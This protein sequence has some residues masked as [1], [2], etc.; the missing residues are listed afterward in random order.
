MNDKALYFDI[1]SHDAELV[2]DMPSNEFFRLGQFA[3]GRNGKVE[4]TD[5]RK[6][7]VKQVRK[8]D[9]VIGHNIH[10]FD[11]TAIFGKDSSEPLE[12]AA[13]RKVFDTMVHA[14]LVNQAP[15]SY[16]NRK[17]HTFYTE[18]NVGNVQKWFGLDQQCFSLN[19]EGKIGDLK[20][21]AKKYGGYG[22]IPLDDPEFVQYAE[23]DVEAV[24]EYAA[25]LKLMGGPGF[26]WSYAWREQLLW[27]LDA[28]NTRNG[29][30]VDRERAQARYDELLRE[31]DIVMAMLVEAYDFPTEGKQPWKSK[32]GKEAIFN[33][34]AEVGI[35]PG[36]RP[37]WAKTATGNPSLGGEV[38]LAL[39]EGTPA[40][41]LGRGL[42]TLLGQRSL[43]ELALTSRRAD[44]KAHPGITRFQ[45][46]GR[47]SVTKPGLTVW[48]ARGEGA[49]EKAYFTASPGRKLVEL[50]YSN[51]DARIVAAL[52]G[53][54]EFA[55]RFAPGVDGHELTGRIVYGDELYDSNPKEYRQLAKMQG[56]AWSYRV[57][58]KGLS[59]Q[60]GL[61]QE[62]TKHFI[63][64]MNK[65]YSRV[66]AWQNRASND[67]ES[68]YVVNEWG[69]VLKVNP[70]R[71]YT[72][73][74]ALLGQ[75]GTREIVA[76]A[77]IRI[78]TKRPEVITWLVAQVHDALIWDIPEDALE[79][80]VP[81]IQENM[82][83]W[84][85]PADGS[86]QRI[87]F[88]V[89]AGAPSDNWYE[90]GH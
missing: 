17:G 39:T 9:I 55:M 35:S 51:A 24:R 48:T 41:D 43:A 75:S 78:Y 77:L 33:A 53:D 69:R 52:S 6:D 44:G 20:A 14:T 65:K 81:F 84:V 54:P 12:M 58:A 42:A 88:P 49:I 22:L 40:E 73:A 83:D 8:A 86:G 1:E 37:D 72:Q 32:A 71:S 7:L 30:T 26:S 11:L 25:R 74:P 60:T 45:T 64:S 76:D 90:A 56:H 61:P 89:A 63:T 36:T 2:W 31:R 80:A 4:L 29:F 3:W 82:E 19:L 23:Q 79:W 59:I 5:S 34:L 21:L 27:A 62:T 13:G 67:G 15:P 87:H 10:H 70:A 57:G 38:L 47:T 46:S 85:E 16:Q 50:D 28:Q 18:R 68:G 66:V